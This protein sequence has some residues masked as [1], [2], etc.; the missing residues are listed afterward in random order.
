MYDTMVLVFTFALFLLVYSFLGYPLTLFFIAAILRRGKKEYYP[1]V[2]PG[3]MLVFPCCWEGKNLQKKIDNCTEIDYPPDKLGIVAVADGPTPET[4]AV[5]KRAEG[6]GILKL[7]VNPK[8][9]GKMVALSRALEG[10]D[11]EIFVVTDADT[12]LE[13][14]HLKELVKPFADPQVGATT[15][16]VRYSNV[17][18]TGISRTQGIY[19]EFELLTRKAEN[20]MGN[21]INVTGTA[22]AIRSRIFKIK[23]PR[24]PDDFLAPLQARA[25]G[26]RVVL[27]ESVVAKDYSP[28]STGALFVRRV[29]MITGGLGSL[30]RNP[31]YLN[32][33]RFPLLAWQ[34]WSH[35]M[36][37]WLYPLFL[38][39]ILI[40]NVFLAHTLFWQILLGAQILLY[41]LGIL[42]GVLLKLGRELPLLSSIWYFLLTGAASLSAFFN[43]LR[44][45]H[46]VMWQET[47]RR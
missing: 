35:K 4:L 2:L 41:M 29:R 27:Q 18:E 45:R 31:L 24:W 47:A 23:D 39:F 19:W 17:G 12:L 40:S 22:Y 1:N 30:L 42:G 6:K 25:N 44:G 46:Y 21:L 13:P 20:L 38:I 26:K 10:C 8:R 32:P 36:L 3:V 9:L 33:F 34:V 15:G 5:L 37:R 14:H 43:V 11:R 7:L 16:I 28:T